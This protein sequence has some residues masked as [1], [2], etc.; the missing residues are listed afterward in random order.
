MKHL[1]IAGVLTT[2][3]VAVIAIL[4]LG[5]SFAANTSTNTTLGITVGTI[6]FSKDTGDSMDTYFSHAASA[7]TT[8]DI[9]TYAADVV[10]ISAASTG[11]HRF[12][13]SDLKGSIFT[14]TLQS[15]DLTAADVSGVQLLIPK[16]GIG[17]TGTTRLGTGK[18]LTAA[19]TGAVDIGTAPV[20]FVS[21]TDNSWVSKFSQE[22]T[23]NVAV[24]AAQGPGSYTGLLT[25]TY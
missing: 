5:Q 3:A 24:P 21:R 15:S 9:G 6:T 12:T 14:I 2:I 11:D 13:V 17:Y 20:T 1:K 25:F 4:N 19:P 8:M 22:I 18:A 10:A 7:A 16:A 23:L